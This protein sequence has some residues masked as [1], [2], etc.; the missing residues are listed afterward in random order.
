MKKLNEDGQRFENQYKLFL[1]KAS[2][3]LTHWST[4][5][6]RTFTFLGMKCMNRQALLRLL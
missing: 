3:V 5:C 1:N 2:E 4:C 6:G